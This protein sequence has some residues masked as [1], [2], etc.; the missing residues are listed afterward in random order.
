MPCLYVTIYKGMAR[1]VVNTPVPAPETPPL[2]EW[3]LEIGVDSNQ[4]EPF[5]EFAKFISVKA[6]SACC[7][8]FGKDPK[9][10]HHF[11]PMDAGEL[12][13]YGVYPG[14]KIAVTVYS[15]D[16]PYMPTLQPM[17]KPFT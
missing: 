2:A 12:R 10:D 13:W 5:P 9:A 15:E 14:H 11:H 17:P 3:S 7:L 6:M 8:A 1:D 16:E 4:S